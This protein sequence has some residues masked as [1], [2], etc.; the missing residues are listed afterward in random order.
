MWLINALSRIF[1]FLVHLVVTVI[2]IPLLLGIDFIFTLGNVLLPRKKHGQVS[3]LQTLPL[4][5]KHEPPTP[6]DS[7][8]P[9]VALNMLANHGV[10][11]RSG[12]GIP[13]TVLEK[14]VRQTY[15]TSPTFARLVT[16]YAADML[17]RD[18]KRDTLDLSDLCVHNGIEHDASFTRLDTALQHDQ[19][20]PNQDLVEFVLSSATGKD[21]NGRP[22]L[23]TG[24]LIRISTTRRADSRSVNSQYTQSGFHKLVGSSNRATLTNIFGGSIDDLTTI[25]RE[26]RLPHNWE[27]SNRSQFG[28]TIATLN[29]TV[30]AVELGIKEERGPRRI[31]LAGDEL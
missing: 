19:S 15:N 10:I 13:F 17:G 6:A 22:R 11:A 2:S 31:K 30:F 12:R 4:W 25:L 20:K 14:A 8:S 21:K 27:P 23:T 1:H 16:K 24:D 9:C 5:P 3:K 29:L 7:R 28:V 18:F 26:E